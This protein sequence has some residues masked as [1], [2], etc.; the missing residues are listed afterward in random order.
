MSENEVMNYKNKIKTKEEIVSELSRLKDK[1][2]VMCH[3]CFDIAHPGHIRHLTFAKSK[4]DIL[5]VSITSDEKVRKGHDR[6]YIPQ[7][8]RAENLAAFELVDYVIIAYNFTPIN[9]IPVKGLKPRKRHRK[10]NGLL[11]RMAAG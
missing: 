6:P 10:K 2:V 7:E 3:G 11:S 1:T 9:C 4:G 5:I 8:L